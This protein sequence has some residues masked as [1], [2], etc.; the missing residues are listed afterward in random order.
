MRSTLGDRDV[1]DSVGIVGGTS[2]GFTIVEPVSVAPVV[3][4]MPQM[5]APVAAAPMASMAPTATFAGP[6]AATSGAAAVSTGGG[7]TGAFYF[8]TSGEP[9]PSAAAPAPAGSQVLYGQYAPPKAGAKGKGKAKGKG[10]GE[11]VTVKKGDTLKEIAKRTDT[12]VKQL[13]KVNHDVIGNTSRVVA[14]QV[15]EIPGDG[16]SKAGA[17]KKAGK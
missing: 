8:D 15:L 11:D 3:M 12:S 2:S 1:F 16:E 10:D 6:A 17:K 5:V 14:G 7:P 4:A 9:A 13:K